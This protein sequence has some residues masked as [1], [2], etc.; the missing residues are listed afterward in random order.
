MMV[1]KCV[2]CPYNEA[3]LWCLNPMPANDEYGKCSYIYR[4]GMLNEKAFQDNEVERSRITIVEGDIRNVD[5]KDKR[6]A[7]DGVIERSS[8]ATRENETVKEAD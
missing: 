5:A 7:D 3:G 1:C 2:G 4:G 8:F 6:R